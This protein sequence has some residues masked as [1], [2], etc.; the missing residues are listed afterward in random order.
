MHLQKSLQHS[1][2]NLL[3][4]FEYKLF[5]FRFFGLSVILLTTLVVNADEEHSNIHSNSKDGISGHA[6]EFDEFS[7]SIK[8]CTQFRQSNQSESSNLYHKAHSKLIVFH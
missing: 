6:E 4:N 5:Y 7:D 8:N 1:T 2:F 3:D